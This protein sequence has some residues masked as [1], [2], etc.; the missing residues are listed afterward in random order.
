MLYVNSLFTYEIY[1][2]FVDKCGVILQLNLLES[3]EFILDN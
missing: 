1:L 3:V 2:F